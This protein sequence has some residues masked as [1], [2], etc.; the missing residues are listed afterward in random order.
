MPSNLLQEDP[1]PLSEA[2]VN[3]IPHSNGKPVSHQTAWRWVHQGLLTPDGQRVKLEVV[4][5][6]NTP[7]TTAAAVQRFFD[8]LTAAKLASSESEAEE[9]VP[10]VA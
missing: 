6:G 4:Y 1:V 8:R 7:M 10:C 5:R 2:R 3:L 9:S